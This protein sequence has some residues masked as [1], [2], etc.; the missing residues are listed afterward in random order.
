MTNLKERNNTAI[1]D[2]GKTHIKLILFDTFNFKELAVYQTKN[3]ILN[4]TPYPHYDLHSM[5]S[6]IISSLK[7]ISKNFPIDTIF[8]STHGACLALIGNEKLVLPILDYEYEGPEEISED[9]EKTRLS[10]SCTGTPRMAAGLNLAA[11]IYWQNKKFSS[12]FG[13][14]DTILFWPQ[15]WSYWLSGVMASEISYASSH[16]DLWNIRENEFIDL[17]N[18]KISSKVKFPKI[19]PASEILGPI[20]KDLAEKTGLS[21][22]VMIYCGGHDSSLTLASAYLNYQL[23]ITVLSTGT[24]ITVFSIKKNNDHINNQNGVMISCDCFGNKIP[25]FRFPGGKIFENNLKIENKSKQKRLDI[26][27][28]DIDLINFEDME[29][30]K[31]INNKTNKQI[32]FDDINYENA[33]YLISEVLA[34]QTLTGLENI[35]ADGKILISGPF[36]NNNNFL[37]ML[38][39]NWTN[40]IIIEDSHLGLCNGIASLINSRNMSFNKNT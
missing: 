38:K 1:L 15:Y 2:I 24:W 10:F 33:N 7:K 11:Q 36:I 20:K 37:N 28:S 17:S 34:K 26:S 22:K 12:E 9:Y 39:K 19:R 23:P 6:F 4:T 25:N 3:N 13:Q 27:L 32:R 14:V 31:F 8:T 21:E 18:Y 29:N 35:N 40:S 5:E 30:A 16:S